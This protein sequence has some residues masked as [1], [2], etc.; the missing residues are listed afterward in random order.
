MNGESRI[1]NGELQVLH[2]RH[3]CHSPFS[4]IFLIAHTKAFNELRPT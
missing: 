3:T 2:V 1:E 4:I